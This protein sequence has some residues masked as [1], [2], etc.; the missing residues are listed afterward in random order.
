MSLQLYQ[1][2]QKSFLLDFKSLNTQDH[3]DAARVKRMTRASMS[4][5]SDS[6]KTSFLLLSL[7]WY[8]G[9]FLSVLIMLS[10]DKK[11]LFVLVM[12]VSVFIL[13]LHL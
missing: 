13:V 2:D 12:N 8:G 5:A 4:L 6:G 7:L 3:P 10:A 1:V 9:P 11:A